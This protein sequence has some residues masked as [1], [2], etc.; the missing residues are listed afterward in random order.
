MQVEHP[1]QIPAS[2]DSVP[3][4]QNAVMALGSL[5]N[6]VRSLFVQDHVPIYWI[7][8]MCVVGFVVLTMLIG[9]GLLI[10]CMFKKRVSLLTLYKI[11]KANFRVALPNSTCFTAFTA[12]TSAIWFILFAIHQFRLDQQLNPDELNASMFWFCVLCAPF[13]FTLY[14]QAIEFCD[15]PLIKTPSSGW[16]QNKKVIGIFVRIFTCIV[17]AAIPA[18]AI[19]SS[20]INGYNNQQDY[21][22]I[23]AE[24]MQYFSDSD[25]S[26][27]GFEMNGSVAGA[28]NVLRRYEEEALSIWKSLAEVYNNAKWIM[29]IWACYFGFL[30]AL[31]LYG[32]VKLY[33]VHKNSMKE[34]DNNSIRTTKLEGDVESILFDS[35]AY[36]NEKQTQQSNCQFLQKHKHMLSAM[37]CIMFL[38]IYSFL[39]VQLT[40]LVE[41]AQITQ[42]VGRY[43]GVLCLLVLF[44]SIYTI[45]HLSIMY[46]NKGRPSTNS[47]GSKLVT[48]SDLALETRSVDTDA[49]LTS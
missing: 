35:A 18:Y 49:T 9:W 10:A 20:I 14:V 33:V 17:A 23:V 5:H 46:A 45:V 12:S 34:S 25:M 29:I 27:D 3:N 41:M 4:D 13:W 11:P 40:S 32:A 42:F 47:S 26:Q 28:V 48:S 43:L 37:V 2:I 19:F 36:G 6:L 8:V 44:S 31:Y 24:V 7:Y 38:I 15:L 16:M 39:S 30:L 22:D 1:Y 21:E